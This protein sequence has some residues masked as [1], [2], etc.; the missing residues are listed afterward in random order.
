ML[1]VATA[2]GPTHLHLDV[3]RLHHVHCVAY[4]TPN[5]VLDH[6]YGRGRD[7][8]TLSQHQQRVVVP[9]PL[10]ICMGMEPHSLG[11]EPH[12][13]GMENIQHGNETV[14]QVNA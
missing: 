6:S 10:T 1:P 2:T 9:V 13:L 7:V 5:V 4:G 3:P 14:Q 12:S 11:I 8:T